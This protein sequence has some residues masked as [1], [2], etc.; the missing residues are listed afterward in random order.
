MS[1]KTKKKYTPKVLE[2]PATM[3]FNK[4]DSVYNDLMSE[5]HDWEAEWRQVSENLLPGRGIY[6]TYAKPRK[7]KLTNPKIVN[8]I[9]EAALYVLTSGMHSGL[10][11]PSREWFRLEWE[12]S[13]INDVEPLKAW[14]QECHDILNADLHR[15]NFYSVINSFY[16]EHTGFGTGCMYVGEDTF[17]DETPFRFELLTAG[18]YSFATGPHGRANVICRTIVKTP[19]QVVEQFP[20]TVSAELHARV[21][22]N[23]A[24]IDRR[25]VVLLEHVVKEKRNGFA[26]TKVVYEYQGSAPATH[27]DRGAVDGGSSTGQGKSPL[28]VSGFHEFPYPISRWGTIGSDVYGIGPG[29]RAIPYIKR[30]Q[31]MDKTFL[32]SAHKA[33]QP[34]H[35]IPARM[36]GRENT[37]PGGRNYYSNPQEVITAIDSKRSETQSLLIAMERLESTIKEIFFNDIFLTASRDPNASPLKATQVNVQEQEKMLRLGPVIERLQHEFLQP[38]IERCFNIELRKGRFPELSPELAEIA[39][40]Y[41]ISL[42]SPLATAQRSMAM[43]GINTFMG[44]VGQYAQFDESVLD[45]VNPDLAVREIADI[46]GVQVGILRPQE[47]VDAIRKQRQQAQKAQQDQENAMAQAG[48]QSQGDLQGAQ[49]RKTSAEAGQIN[50]ESQQLAQEMEMV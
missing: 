50:L 8:P 30:L 26:Y 27:P 21:A 42:V 1:K 44:A 35:N 28:E 46:N 48:V 23:A 7:R 39:G 19:R 14:L 25:D 24:G 22:T 37:L 18:E 11:S 10:T 17:T 5:R 36:R 3:S 41:K 20:T 34:P 31:E 2:A 40:D 13:R 16:V 32:M 45:N 49:S 6:Q 43:G 47:E 4:V 33:A 38:V 15:S 12:D 9:A 29:A